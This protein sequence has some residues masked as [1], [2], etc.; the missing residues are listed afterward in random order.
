MRLEHVK[1]CNQRARGARAAEERKSSSEH[2]AE[3]HRKTNAS[4]HNNELAR[5]GDQKK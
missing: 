4:I 1:L 5:P 3:Q 2:G